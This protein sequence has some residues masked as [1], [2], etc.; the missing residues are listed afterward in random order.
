MWLTPGARYP[1]D[2]EN[3]VYVLSHN[4]NVVLSVSR[5]GVGERLLGIGLVVL[6][7]YVSV[8]C[9]RIHLS[10]R[11]DAELSLLAIRRELEP[12]ISLRGSR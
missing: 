1:I 7:E 8:S 11:W 12:R 4:A 2:D 3:V 6:Y 9:V 5:G 10:Y